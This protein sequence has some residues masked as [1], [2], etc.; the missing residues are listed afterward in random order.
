[1]LRIST[2]NMLV[3][4]KLPNY[5]TKFTRNFKSSIQNY[6]TVHAAI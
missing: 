1:M 2:Y 6:F 5:K 4:H 3:Y